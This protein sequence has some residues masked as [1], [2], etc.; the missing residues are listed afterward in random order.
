MNAQRR[1]SIQEVIDQLTD[2]QSTVE[3]L[4]DEEQEAYDNLPENLQ[5]SER[6]EAMSES[7]DNLDS[8]YNSIDEVLE[9]LNAAIEG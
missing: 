1:K 7:A 2:L 3:N 6:G 9:Y 8:A 5:G 4:K